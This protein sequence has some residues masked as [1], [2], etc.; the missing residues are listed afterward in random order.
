MIHSRLSY[1][2]K[3]PLWEKSSKSAAIPRDGAI[4][5]VM[6]TLSKRNENLQVAVT[7]WLNRVLSAMYSAKTTMV[8]SGLSYKCSK[9]LIT[10]FLYI[11]GISLDFFY[12]S[13]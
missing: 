3:P 10:I 13:G 5:K 6:K 9:E 8:K 4:A 1:I 2:I 7:P 12:S 11:L